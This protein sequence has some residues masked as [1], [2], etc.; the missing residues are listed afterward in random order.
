MTATPRPVAADAT[1]HWLERAAC[2][3]CASLLFQSPSDGT[4]AELRDQIAELPPRERSAASALLPPDR[5]TWESQ[6]HDVLGPGGIPASASSYDPAAIAGRGP[7][8]ARIA[9]TYR[10]F[11]FT[12]RSGEVPDHISVQLAFLSY[13][14]LK[15]AF[16]LYERA[17]EP[18]ALTEEAYTRF[19]GED[20][21]FWIP[22]FGERLAGI[23]SGLYAER[24]AWAA[25]LMEGEPG[26]RSG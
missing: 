1:R 23:D 12:P 11:A 15:I 21:T 17:A 25:H 5:E 9:G 16:A 22:V 26:S 10:A 4:L 13:L 8:L 2:W 6:F 14:A 3:R 24:L 18:A 7:L 19:L 20:V